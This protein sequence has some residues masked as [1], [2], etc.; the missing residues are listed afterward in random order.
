MTTID[1]T[2]SAGVRLLGGLPREVEAAL[3]RHYGRVNK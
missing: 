1:D 2:A 3:R